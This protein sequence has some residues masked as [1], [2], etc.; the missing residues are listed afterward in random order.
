MGTRNARSW[1]EDPKA[2]FSF[3]QS[4]NRKNAKIDKNGQ[5]GSPT[6]EIRRQ[7]V[8]ASQIDL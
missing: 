8:A 7:P 2:L 1:S 5:L 6:Q 4:G 3:E